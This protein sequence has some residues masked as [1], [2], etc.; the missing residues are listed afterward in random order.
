MKSFVTNQNYA[1][2]QLKNA[3]VTFKKWGI[4]DE[5]KMGHFLQIK[6][7]LSLLFFI[8]V[9]AGHKSSS[10]SIKD[11]KGIFLRISLNLKKNTIET[12]TDDKTFLLYNWAN[13]S[14]KQEYET[15]IY[16]KVLWRRIK[17]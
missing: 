14:L 10:A 17:I 13:I 4:N 12:E 16:N 7:N 15:H 2:K 9:L 8:L 5:K 6:G 3:K 11:S 1:P